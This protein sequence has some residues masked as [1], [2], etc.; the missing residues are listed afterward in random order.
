MPLYGGILIFLYSFLLLYPI[1]LKLFVLGVIAVFTMIVPML[2]IV[3][4]KTLGLIKTVA[5]NHR[6]DRKL[7]YLISLLSYF[8]CGLIL[9]KINLPLWVVGFVAGGLASLLI[10]SVITMKWK[11]SA[12][13]TGMGGLLGCAFYLSQQ[14]AML[15]LWMLLLFILLTGALGTSRI[16]LGRHTFGQVVAGTCNGF[17]CVYLGMLLL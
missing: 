10:A 15:P 1:R 9:I 13:L 12:H 14:Y 4:L 5:L 7:P 8:V 16:Y 2:G 6:E 11:I 17:L 3:L